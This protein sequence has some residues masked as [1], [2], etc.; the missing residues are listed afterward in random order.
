MSLSGR[1]VSLIGTVAGFD[2]GTGWGV[3]AAGDGTGYPFH[4]TAIADGT[5]SIEAGAPVV[6]H[7]TPGHLGVW[8]ATGVT[9]QQPAQD[10]P[11]QFPPSP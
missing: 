7:L 2:D 6:F 8:E 10:P 4:C 1:G 11:Q 9:P 3:I 5:R